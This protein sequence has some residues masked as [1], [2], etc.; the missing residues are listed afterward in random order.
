MEWENKEEK[1]RLAHIKNEKTW[2]AFAGVSVKSSDIN[3]Q[4]TWVKI[5]QFGK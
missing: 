1:D 3:K 2:N 4:W 5:T